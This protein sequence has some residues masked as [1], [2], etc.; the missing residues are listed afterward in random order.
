MQL[1]F[2]DTSALRS[3]V[4]RSPGWGEYTAADTPRQGIELPNGCT[5]DTTRQRTSDGE[6]ALEVVF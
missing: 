1:N 4:R 2:W 6:A 3:P 5:R